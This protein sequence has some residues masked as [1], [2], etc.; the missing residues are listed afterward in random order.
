MKGDRKLGYVYKRY[1]M[2]SKYQVVVRVEVDS[3]TTDPTTDKKSF[4]LVRALNENDLTNEWRK[5]LISNRGAV[6][7]TEMRTNS[8]K[9][10]KWLCQAYLMDTQ[11]VKLGFISRINQKESTKH[12]VLGV[13][14]Y[15]FKD[16]AGILNFKIKDCWIIIKYLIDYLTKQ[17]NGKYALVKM[18][19]K[20][21][22]RIFR[23]PEE[24]KEEK[25][26]L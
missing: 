5:K 3:Y 1:T 24:K 6:F 26:E 22:V 11:T 2:D 21:Q 17:P 12:A 19:F 4:C 13:D 20:P 23:I 15:S 18:P 9:V 7:S 14:N 8:C 10:F 25:D 16:L